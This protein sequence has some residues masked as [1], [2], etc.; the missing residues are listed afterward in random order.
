MNACIMAAA[1][2][3]QP[4]CVGLLPRVEDPIRIQNMDS[5]PLSKLGFIKGKTTL[6]EA[7][8]IMKKMNMSGVTSITYVYE[9]PPVLGA[10]GADYQLSVHI[11]ENDAYKESISL[12]AGNVLPYDISLKFVSAEKQVFLLALYRDPT[13]M[14]GDKDFQKRHPSSPPRIMVYSTENGAFVKKSR[15]DIGW[16]TDRMGGMTDPLLVGTD[17]DMG[18][19]FLARDRSGSVWDNAFI[20]KMAGGKLEFN[21]VP[22]SE[23]SKCS[24]VVNYMYGEKADDAKK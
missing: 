21:P 4:G 16:L 18:I 23:A 10:I 9:K 14:I 1:I 5:V 6:A 7:E 24:C 12:E 17:M 19:L 15:F 11:F 22:L 3:I 8:R 2:S 20:L 13:D